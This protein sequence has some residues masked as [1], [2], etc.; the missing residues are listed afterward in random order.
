MFLCFV[1]LA[2]VLSNIKNP[3]A[4][5]ELSSRYRVVC[6]STFALIT[7]LAVKQE[8]NFRRKP[9]LTGYKPNSMSNR[10]EREWESYSGNGRI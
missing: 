6:S 7:F 8:K 4:Y 2:N 1:V 3:K 5:Q 9:V 10:R